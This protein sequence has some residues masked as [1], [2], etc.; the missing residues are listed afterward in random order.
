VG[1]GHLDVVPEDPIVTDLEGGDPC[2]LPLLPLKGGDAVAR[3][4]R[5]LVD[6]HPPVFGADPLEFGIVEGALHPLELGREPTPTQPLGEAAGYRRDRAERREEEEEV[7]RSNPTRPELP[8]QPLEIVYPLDP[9][10][11]LA[12]DEARPDERLDRI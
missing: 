6:E 1:P 8:D 9:L 11:E 12:P 5:R 10:A 3:I 4:D 7:V 2:P